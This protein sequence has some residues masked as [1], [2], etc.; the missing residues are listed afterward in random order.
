VRSVGETGAAPGTRMTVRQLFFNTPARLKFMK[1]TATELGHAANML[2]RQAL[3][4]PHINFRM[5][6]GERETLNL[7][8]AASIIDRLALIWGNDFAGDLLHGAR[9]TE[10]L[11]VN[12]YFGTP[13]LTRSNR[14]HQFFFLNRRPITNR[15]LGKALAD[16]YRGAVMSDR[17]PVAFIFIEIDPA[18]VDVNIHPTK[19]EVRFSNP[20]S[21]FEMLRRALRAALDR[22]RARSAL[23]GARLERPIGADRPALE[24]PLFLSI[25]LDED[26][27]AAALSAL[28]EEERTPPQAAAPIARPTADFSAI[29]PEMR[30]LRQIFGSYL[31]C[32]EGSDMLI[33]DQ[34][35]L[36]ERILYDMLVERSSGADQTVQQMLIPLTIEFPP[37]RAEVLSAHLDMFARIG[38]EIQ[39]FGPKTFA[40]TALARVH[41][42]ARVVDSVREAVDELYMGLNMRAPREILHRLMTISACKN[43]IKAG[44]PL[45]DSE[46]E[47]LIE[48]LK[49]LAQPPTCLH[50]RPLVL[51]M[52]ESQIA[53]AFGRKG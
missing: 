42:E 51:R 25:K 16:A 4:H 7:P 29:S 20:D 32:V 35:A 21:V 6:S 47:A 18:L 46:A 39:P 11:S 19:R 41:S 49:K 22:P 36:H 44:D 33:V 23:E 31:L 43:S 52:S 12:G 45:G 5:T 15:L 14:N 17:F 50:G 38:I 3:A 30:F 1:T 27:P 10:G 24:K 53:R 8:P 48:G 34:H 13:A 26:R 28:E 37:D 9:E 2:Q 40:V